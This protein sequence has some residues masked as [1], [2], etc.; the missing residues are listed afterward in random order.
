MTDRAAAEGIAARAKS[1]NGIPPTDPSESPTATADA[2]KSVTL[3]SVEEEV[4]DDKV[5]SAVRK[6]TKGLTTEPGDLTTELNRAIFCTQ[7]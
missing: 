7:R 5:T 2:D 1:T 3:D 4:E 6:R